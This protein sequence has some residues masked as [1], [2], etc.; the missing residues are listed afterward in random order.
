MHPAE[1]LGLTEP[2]T[3]QIGTNAKVYESETQVG[4]AAWYPQMGGYV[5]RCVIVF[6]KA[7]DCND[8]FDCYVWHDGEFPFT[9]ADGA[10]AVV[11]HCEA[12]QF[13]R[14]GNLVNGLMGQ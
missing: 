4:Y 7:R 10:P 13:V 5:G 14:F 3:E 6:D 12:D 2:T 9:E 1:T 11:H 8:C